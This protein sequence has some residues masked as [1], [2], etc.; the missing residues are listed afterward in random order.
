[1]WLK[2]KGGA[3]DRGLKVAWTASV[4]HLGNPLLESLR[5]LLGKRDW[6]P[7]TSIRMNI[8]RF[9]NQPLNTGSILNSGQVKAH[10]KN[11]LIS[12]QQVDNSSLLTPSPVV[13]SYY[14]LNW[15]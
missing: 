7:Q 10:T 1:M 8:L 13:F 3:V 5:I 9:R 15:G 6:F 4:V 11:F 2:D 12:T 14:L